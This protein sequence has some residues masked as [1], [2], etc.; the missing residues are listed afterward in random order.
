MNNSM[1]Q[2]PEDMSLNASINSNMPD[3][4][5]PIKERSL[6]DIIMTSSPR[7]R[8]GPMRKKKLLPLISLQEE[9]EEKDIENELNGDNY[10]EDVFGMTPSA[11]SEKNLNTEL[12]KTLQEELQESKD[13]D[14]ITV[15]Q[16]VFE[17]DDLSFMLK[18]ERRKTSTSSITSIRTN[19]V[20]H[21]EK[22]R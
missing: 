20:I 8:K 1:K 6:N 21:N 13:L 10:T 2:K 4:L 15:G 17:D 9:M 5:S 11:D 7:G 19:G 16:E 12:N 22:V 18:D 14:D 3:L